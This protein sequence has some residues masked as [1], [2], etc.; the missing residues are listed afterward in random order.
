MIERWKYIGQRT[1]EPTEGN[2]GDN[3]FTRS[4][5]AYSLAAVTSW[6]SPLMQGHCRIIPR[7]IG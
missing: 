5:A 4:A 2:V 1:D 3:D 6:K 7:M